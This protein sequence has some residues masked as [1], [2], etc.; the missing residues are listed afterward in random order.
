MIR[1]SIPVGP[2][3]RMEFT[4]DQ[5]SF[6]AVSKLVDLEDLS[7]EFRCTPR[8]VSYIEESSLF[9]RSSWLLTSVLRLVFVYME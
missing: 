3:W 9:L 7:M 2:T 1:V 5:T 6:L 4:G 8:R